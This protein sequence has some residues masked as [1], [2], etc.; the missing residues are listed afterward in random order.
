VWLAGSQHQGQASRPSPAETA[1]I[2]VGE[3]IG[4]LA[5][6]DRDAFAKYCTW[7]RWR[8]RRAAT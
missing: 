3:A 4:A 8:R 5:D 6:D 1:G 2:V 7:P